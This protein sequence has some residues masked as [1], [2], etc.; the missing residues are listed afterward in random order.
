MQNIG[1]GYPDH[2]TSPRGFLIF[3]ETE[4]LDQFQRYYKSRQAADLNRQTWLHRAEGLRHAKSLFGDFS[5]WLYGQLD[6]EFLY[7]RRLDFLE[8]TL[9][10]ITMG[11]RS[12][13]I[14]NWEDLLEDFPE[15]GVFI[16]RG[17]AE[18]RLKVAFPT[19]LTTVDAIANWC[20]QPSG[21]DDMV[22]T[23]NILF[24]EANQSVL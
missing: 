12:I 21:F 16:N 9:R 1:E 24:G 6:G 17:V 5:Q 8:D 3:G 2:F 7:G 11:Q 4:R 10:F 13:T 14:Q 20:S 18:A 15:T 19:P 23:L 22:C